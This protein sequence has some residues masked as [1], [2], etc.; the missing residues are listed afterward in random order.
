MTTNRTS[1]GGVVDDLRKRWLAAENDAQAAFAAS[2][3]NPDPEA[4]RRSNALRFVAD[5]IKLQFEAA[6]KASDEAR[7]NPLKTIDLARVRD[8]KHGEDR[9]IFVT[10]AHL[11]LVLS[12]LAIAFAARRV[13]T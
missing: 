13:L 12:P 4:S 10:A 5:N 2:M 1:F 11:A 7:A 8:I 3:G 9:S 6:E